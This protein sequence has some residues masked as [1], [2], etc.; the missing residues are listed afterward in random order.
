M[1]MKSSMIEKLRS[2][3]AEERPQLISARYE[4]NIAFFKSK[5]PEIHEFIK[6]GVCP[7]QINIT[8]RFLDII[9]PATLEQS[10]MGM[11]LDDFAE[12]LGGWSHGEWID[13]VNR[14]FY[15]NR[16]YPIHYEI[17]T[18]FQEKL[19]KTLARST[20]GDVERNKG[21][22]LWDED[23][24]TIFS[25][26]VIF[27]GIF[28]G[29]H[30]DYYITRSRISRVLLIE[31]EAERFEVSCYFVDYQY[32]YEKFGVLFLAIGPDCEAEVIKNFMHFDFVS[33]Q[34][35]TRMLPAYISQYNAGF[36]NSVKVMQESASKIFFPLDIELRGIE[37][38]MRNVKNQ[39]P[40]LHGKAKLSSQ[41]RIAIVASGPSLDES[42]D[43]LSRNKA[44]VIIFAVHSAVRSLRQA[45][46]KPDFQ[47]SMET[48]PEK[49]CAS[50]YDLEL[51]E[52]VPFVVYCR[53]DPSWIK[54]KRMPLMVSEREKGQAVSF[55]ISLKNTHPS[56]T[57]MAV[58]LACLFQPHELFFIGCDFGYKDLNKSHARGSWHNQYYMDEKI[59]KQ[60]NV[61]EIFDEVANFS[62]SHVVSTHFLVQAR[63]SVE[64]SLRYYKGTAYN[65]SD[66]ARIAFATPV[67]TNKLK[68]KKYKSKKEDTIAIREAFSPAQERIN[69]S[70]YP[71]TG[72]EKL[73]KYLHHIA[74]KL[75]LDV[76]DW[77]LF[78][79]GVDTVLDKRTS[80]YFKE[81]SDWRMDIYSRM[82]SDLLR[83]WFLMVV[84]SGDKSKAIETYWDG[85]ELFK[86]SLARMKWPENC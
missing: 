6:S 56:T 19:T 72:Q 62:D 53:V 57:N 80:A 48:L 37:N 13:L 45:G 8:E 22:I 66:G 84:S 26:P 42:L 64:K 33:P 86:E 52:D 20:E 69:Y 49:Q 76:F 28:H 25:P 75:S 1:R 71:A 44:K 82:I 68:I 7:Y 2:V 65:V 41:S 50:N 31:P 78:C 24:Q 58:S 55:K 59:E 38:T 39:V 60:V 5:Y 81:K 27:L 67:R 36:I 32:L 23:T 43:W 83:F 77:E 11:S 79:R 74:E 34:V 15:S 9:N 35:W 73:D 14:D 21:M 3:S 10:T 29:L 85:L 30:I 40:V 51:Y 16:D 46:I 70:N 47:F 17:F 63:V 61:D 4:K 18:E 54:D 12:S